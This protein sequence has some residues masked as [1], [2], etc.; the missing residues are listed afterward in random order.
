MKQEKSEQRVT[1]LQAIKNSKMTDVLT[2]LFTNPTIKISDACKALD[3]DYDQFRYWERTHPD[4]ISTVRNLLGEYQR[5]QLLA[6][7]L[8]TSS[9]LTALMEA[10]VSTETGV[11]MKMELHKYLSL[12]RDELARTYHAEPGV[13]SEAQSFLSKG[14][15]TKR[16][17]SR[18]ASL[19]LSRTDSGV[20]IDILRD[21]DILEGQVIESSPQTSNDPQLET[22]TP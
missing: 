3:V 6:L 1:A 14:P 7:E 13:E 16:Q 2:L 18:F 12:I 8:T 20:R 10:A 17:E 11:A 21:E 5:E 19:E 4:F 22:E 15:V 9:A